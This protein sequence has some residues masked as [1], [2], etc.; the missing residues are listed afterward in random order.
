MWNQRSDRATLAQKLINSAVGGQRVSTV[1]VP[2]WMA[3]DVQKALEEKLRPRGG[4][5]EFSRL[6]AQDADQLDEDTLRELAF[7]NWLRNEQR[8]KKASSAPASSPG[9]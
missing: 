1:D 5:G 3:I 7:L 6:Y 2:K 8:A 9:R 4:I